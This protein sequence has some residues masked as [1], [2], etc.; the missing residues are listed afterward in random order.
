MSIEKEAKIV[1]RKGKYCVVGHKKDKSGHYR[2]FG[3]YDS[4]EEAKK[5]LG[6]IYAFKY[7]K[8]E[9]IDILHE[10]SG[11]LYDRGIIHI[12]DAL[13][14]CI[15]SV[16]HEDSRD[17]LAI[18]LGKIVS[19]LKKRSETELAEKIDFLLPEVL[20]LEKTGSGKVPKLKYRISAQRAYNIAKLLKRKYLEGLVDE[21]DFE[22][23]K[24]K[25]LESLLRT[26][27]ILPAP[28][29]YKTLPTD[30]NNWWDHFEKR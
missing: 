2:N 10:V 29:T 14:G 23:E 18:K 5:R 8:S 1:K 11:I 25:E 15:E 16:V 3:C 13:V 6:Q 20:S 9:V 24:M 21:G 12:A 26:G 27:F 28:N 30:I 7:K 19:L 4:K 22:Y 17:N